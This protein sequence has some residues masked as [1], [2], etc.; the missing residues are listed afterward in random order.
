MAKNCDPREVLIDLCA[1]PKPEMRFRA[2]AELMPYLYP[3][4]RSIE[5]TGAA[6]GPLEGRMTLEVVYADKTVPE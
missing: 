4:L 1:S 2:A 5:V 3:T 6:G